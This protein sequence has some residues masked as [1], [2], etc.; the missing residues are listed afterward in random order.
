MQFDFTPEEVWGVA[1]TVAAHMAADGYLVSAEETPWDDAPYVT[2]LQA[3]RR[4]NTAPH[5]LVEVQ[6]ELDYSDRIREFNYYLR[7]GVRHAELLIAVSE[8]TVMHAGTLNK[9]AS[10]GVGLLVVGAG[11]EVAIRQAAKNPALIIHP[12]PILRFGTHSADVRGIFAK[13]ND[14]HRQDA[15]RDMCELVERLTTQ[16]GQYAVGRGVWTIT[17]EQ[18]AAKDWNGQIN[19]LASINVCRAGVPA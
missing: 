18:F 8:D 16:V 7:N 17:R 13:F 3:R 9:L 11:G 4:A 14:G 5:I 19:A 6:G 10:E 2:T 12:D 15:M 1:E